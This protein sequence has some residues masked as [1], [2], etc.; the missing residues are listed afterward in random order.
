MPESARPHQSCGT[1]A[2]LSADATSRGRA[3]LGGVVG[4][5][6]PTSWTIPTSLSRNSSKQLMPSGGSGGRPDDPEGSAA[7]RAPE[8]ADV[9]RT[10]DAINIAPLEANS[11][12][13]HG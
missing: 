6:S 2:P 1:V 13:T 7:R 3:P 10:V 5:G 12:V 4:K 8:G 11:L 9:A